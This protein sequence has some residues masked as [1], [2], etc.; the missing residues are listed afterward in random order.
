MRV[1]RLEHINLDTTKPD[2]TIAFYEQVLG[3]K[4]RPDL[5]PAAS[6]PGAWL[7]C[8]DV[9]VVHLNFHDEA[10]ESAATTGAFNHAAFA[11][12]GFE[13]TCTHLDELGLTYRASDKPERPFQQVFVRDPN[14]VMIE[15]NFAR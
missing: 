14:G 3:L 6:P 11:A 7:F 9:A 2:E 5:R 1:Q 13:D 10:P 15:L 4:N 12:E 8:G